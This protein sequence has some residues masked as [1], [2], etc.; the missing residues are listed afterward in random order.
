M[1]PSWRVDRAR[2]RHLFIYTWPVRPS[3]TVA[4][5]LAEAVSLTDTAT[6][7]SLTTTELSRRETKST[8]HLHTLSFSKA[9]RPHLTGQLC[10]I[11]GISGPNSAIRRY[12][13]PRKAMPLMFRLVCVAG[14]AS[15]GY[16]GLQH[17]RPCHLYHLSRRKQRYST[18]Y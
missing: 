14:Q 12:L 10:M 11:R 8:L 6:P 3:S 9:S 16:R 18:N 15:I 1:R 4:A 17:L 7:P 13:Y 2:S 5:S